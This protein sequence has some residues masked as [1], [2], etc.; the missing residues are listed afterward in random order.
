MWA[1]RC[2]IG[3]REQAEDFIRNVERKF[4]H[5]DVLV[6]DAGQIE[7]GPLEAQRI[8]DFQQA[9][10]TMYW[11][12]VYTTLAAYPAMA[13]RRAGRIVNITSGRREICRPASAAVLRSEIRCGWL[14]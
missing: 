11:G 5:I 4:G 12:T 10:D 8:E 14:Q 2:D 1:F 7:V 6:N 13:R 3:V 9:M